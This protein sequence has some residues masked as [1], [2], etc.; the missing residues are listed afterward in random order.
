MLLPRITSRSSTCGF[1]SCTLVLNRART[2]LQAFSSLVKVHHLYP[3]VL[4]VPYFDSLPAC[5]SC[6]SVPGV[7]KCEVVQWPGKW[8]LS[9]V[10][11]L[12][13]YSRYQPKILHSA[14]DR[15][16]I[17]AAPKRPSTPLSFLDVKAANLKHLKIP[18]P[19]TPWLKA[20]NPQPQTKL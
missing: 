20:L 11:I 5:A 14:I 2:Q 17:S 13:E 15:S 8:V 18:N 1:D 10:S 7:S 3:K 9:G 6:T 19:Y 16:I 12:T 4:D